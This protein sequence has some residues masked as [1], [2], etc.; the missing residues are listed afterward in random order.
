MHRRRHWYINYSD[1]SR[2]SGA[3]TS[4]RYVLQQRRYTQLAVRQPAL[5][6]WKHLQ[7]FLV[8]YEEPVNGTG[9]PS[10]RLG[11]ESPEFPRYAPYGIEI[12][13]NEGQELQ[14]N[15]LATRNSCCM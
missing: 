4:E 1:R 7:M 2:D 12:S 3:L 5:N 11:V 15:N 10:M 14:Y 9:T 8:G 6:A 13:K